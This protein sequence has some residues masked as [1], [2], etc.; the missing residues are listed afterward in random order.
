MNEILKCL[1]ENVSLYIISQNFSIKNLSRM[2]TGMAVAEFLLLL[3]ILYG[4]LGR[5][6]ASQLLCIT[7]P[8]RW[9]GCMVRSNVLNSFFNGWDSSS[10]TTLLWA[11]WVLRFLPA[12]SLP[13]WKLQV[14]FTETI[15]QSAACPLTEGINLKKL[16]V[17]FCL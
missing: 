2:V 11:V 15:F 9:L 7:P 17:F 3:M 10:T 8:R 16:I 13:G 6:A 1:T 4:I 14:V 12:C 5:A